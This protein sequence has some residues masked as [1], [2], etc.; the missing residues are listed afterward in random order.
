MSDLTAAAQRERG[1]LD[2]WMFVSGLAPARVLMLAARTAWVYQYARAPG[3]RLKSLALRLGYPD[4]VRFGRHIRWMTGHAPSSLRES[5]S[6]D[7]LLQLITRRI[8][9]DTR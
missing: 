7:E 1:S 4:L 8:L 3:S 6:P 2:R 9:R 5:V